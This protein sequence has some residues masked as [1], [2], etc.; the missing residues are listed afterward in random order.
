MK[1]HLAILLIFLLLSVCT[2]PE[3]VVELGELYEVE[4]KLYEKNSENPYTGNVI[5]RWPDGSPHTTGYVHLGYRAGEWITK[6]PDEVILSKT[7][8]KNGKL[9]TKGSYYENGET[10]RWSR[11]NNGKLESETSYHENGETHF[12]KDYWPNGKE[13]SMSRNNEKGENQILLSW[14]EDGKY[15]GLI[16]FVHPV[17]KDTMIALFT[18]GE[19]TVTGIQE[20][21]FARGFLEYLEDNPLIEKENHN[22]SPKEK[23]G[24]SKG[25]KL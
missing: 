9:E 23:K 22:Q 8:Y 10:R 21:D 17:S 1:K 16:S 12:S 14:D 19:E 3:K 7:N 13:K 2:K 11:Y 4:G 25:D 15:D 24:L 20:Y 5:N 18:H 6:R